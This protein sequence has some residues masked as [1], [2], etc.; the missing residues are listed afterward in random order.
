MIFILEL[1]I[2]PVILNTMVYLN[3]KKIFG[4]YKMTVVLLNTQEVKQKMFL[5]N[6][7]PGARS[8]DTY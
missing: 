1:Y 2:K 6:G 3:I 4:Y 8:I 7:D 5:D